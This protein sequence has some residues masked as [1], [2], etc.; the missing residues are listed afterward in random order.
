M[1]MHTNMGMGMGLD[2][3]LVPR[4]V[5]VGV[6]VCVEL[7]GDPAGEREHVDA[8]VGPGEVVPK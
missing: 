2:P 8:G 4:R 6:I 5:E 1:C 3:S 7:L